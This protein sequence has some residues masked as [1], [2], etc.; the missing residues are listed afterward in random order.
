MFE[1]FNGKLTRNI[2]NFINISMWVL[3]IIALTG[4]LNY[5]PIY[6][7]TLDTIIKLYVAIFLIV[8]FNP[9]V[10]IVMTKFDKQFAWSGGILLLLSSTIT[11]AFKSYIT[12]K[13]PIVYNV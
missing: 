13:I 11:V 9:F 1:V 8:R 4:I 10:E 12:S 7:T 6:L 3:Y 2:Y 5:N